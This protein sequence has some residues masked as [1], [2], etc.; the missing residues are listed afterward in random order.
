MTTQTQI[1]DIAFDQTVYGRNIRRLTRHAEVRCIEV[2]E[3]TDD[4]PGRFFDWVTLSAERGDLIL[5]GLI[6]FNWDVRPVYGYS[7][8]GAMPTCWNLA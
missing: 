7:N 8:G 3:N 4:L 2:V 5:T 1:T 6:E